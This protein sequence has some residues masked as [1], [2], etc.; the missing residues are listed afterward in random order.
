M[1]HGADGAKLSKRHGALGV[2]AY[3]D[4]MGVL[5]EALFNYLLRLGW[6]HGDEEIIARDQAVE[7]FDIGHVGKSPSRFDIAKLMNLNGHYIREAED[8]RLAALMAAR[9]DRR[10]GARRCLTKR[11]AGAQGPRQGSGSNWRQGAAFLFA[12]P[13]A[14]RWTPRRTRCSRAEARAN[15]SAAFR[16]GW[17]GENDWTTAGLEASLKAMAED[18]GL[19]LGKLAQPLR[20]ALTGQTTSPGIFDVLT[21]LGREESSGAHRRAG[22]SRRSRTNL[23]SNRW[24]AIKQN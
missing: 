23:R 15:C 13:A 3:R 17:S 11:H 5:P 10:G 2:D 18:I 19:G 21:L 7:W 22:G 16:T 14:R 6:G 1:I 24:W 9:M 8:A 20:A 4:E 12:P